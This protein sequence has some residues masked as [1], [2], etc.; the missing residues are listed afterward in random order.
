MKDLLHSAALSCYGRVYCT[1]TSQICTVP[2][3]CPILIDPYYNSPGILRGFELRTPDHPR[4][5]ISTSF[6]S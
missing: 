4:E 3:L 1:E 2:L 6:T 5:E